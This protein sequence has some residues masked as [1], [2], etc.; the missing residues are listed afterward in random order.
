MGGKG[1][2]RG[3]KDQPR[4]LIGPRWRNGTFRSRRMTGINGRAR[5]RGQTLIGPRWRNGKFRSRYMTGLNGRRQGARLSKKIG[6]R[7]PDGRRFLAP[8]NQC[9]C[10][11]RKYRHASHCGACAKVKR[12]AIP[13]KFSSTCLECGR[14]FRKHLKSLSARQRQSPIPQVFYCSRRCYYKAR[15]AHPL[16]D[17]ARRLSQSVAAMTEH[18]DG[19]ETSQG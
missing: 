9:E 1:S 4:R 11:S 15:R 3:R 7:L 16:L 6:P 18:Y 14:A 17:H 8:T 19:E 12:R 5:G 13:P 10:G 2:G